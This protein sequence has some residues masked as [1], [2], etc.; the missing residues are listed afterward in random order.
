V[1]LAAITLGLA[2]AWSHEH[3]RAACLQAWIDADLLSAT[4]DCSR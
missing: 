1:A 3:R 2:V 4:P